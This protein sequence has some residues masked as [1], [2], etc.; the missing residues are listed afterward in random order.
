MSYFNNV[1]NFERIVVAVISHINDKWED[2]PID[3]FT[4]KY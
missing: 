4:K 1:K 3:E 2:T